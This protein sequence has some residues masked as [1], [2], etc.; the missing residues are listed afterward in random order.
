MVRPGNARPGHGH[1]QGNVAP[2]SAPSPAR[3]CRSRFSRRTMS[4]VRCFWRQAVPPGHQPRRNASH[5]RASGSRFTCRYGQSALPHAPCSKTRRERRPLLQLPR[6]YQVFF[7]RTAATLQQA[8]RSLNI[9]A[10]GQRRLDYRRPSKHLASQHEHNQHG[11][12]GR[13]SHVP[14]GRRCRQA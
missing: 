5:T 10:Y 4:G 7:T 6:P 11:D 12:A 13:R 2:T 1:Q 3:S 8:P 9:R 14:A